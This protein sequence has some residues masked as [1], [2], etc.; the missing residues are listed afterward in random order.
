M[1]EAQ[2]GSELATGSFGIRAGQGDHRGRDATGLSS[3]DR[4]GNQRRLPSP[5][6]TRDPAGPCFRLVH[7]F[8]GAIA[9]KDVTLVVGA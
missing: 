8:I 1:I 3:G 2:L 5:F 4:Y 7:N 6:L 9:N